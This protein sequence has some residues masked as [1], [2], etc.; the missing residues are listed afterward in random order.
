M[1][2]L[3]TWGRV[4]G[5]QTTAIVAVMVSENLQDKYKFIFD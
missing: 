4:M 1:A 2:L 3:A 5:V